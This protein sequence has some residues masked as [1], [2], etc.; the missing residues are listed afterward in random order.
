VTDPDNTHL[1]DLLDHVWHAMAQLG[2]SLDESQWG[3]PTECPGWTVQ[4]VF[5]HITAVER[6]LLDD[7]LPESELPDDLPHVKNRFG[8]RNE[9]WIESRRAWSGADV[10]AEFDATI[11]ARLAVLRTLDDDAFAA[12]SWTPLGQ[13]TLAGLLGLRVVDSWVHEQDVRRA[14]ERPG[15]LDS[16]AA[17]H[18]VDGM[19]ALLPYVIGK[20][21]GAADGSTVVLSLTG[22]LVRSVAVATNAGRAEVLEHVP[23]DPSVEIVLATDIYERLACGRIDPDETL[24]AGAVRIEGDIELGAAVLRNL[25]LMF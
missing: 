24:I 4:D 14:V 18:T 15:D 25:N 2:A 7:P 6:A 12:P 9:R 8:T 3:T 21:V 1:V 17:A 13:G 19:L 11:D 22:P 23:A 16:E 20:K 5:V 10:L